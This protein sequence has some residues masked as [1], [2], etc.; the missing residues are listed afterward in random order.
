ML[1]LRQQGKVG[2]CHS[3]EFPRKVSLD[4]LSEFTDYIGSLADD[5]CHLAHGI[6]AAVRVRLDGEVVLSDDECAVLGLNLEVG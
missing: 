3:R 6:Y 4:V 2:R 1:S 5:E